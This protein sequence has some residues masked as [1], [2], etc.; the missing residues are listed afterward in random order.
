MHYKGKLTNTFTLKTTQ[1]HT[2]IHAH[3]KKLRKNPH[4]NIRKHKYT[5]THTLNNPQHSQNH[6]LQNT[7]LQKT[8]H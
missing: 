2:F 5:Q 6:T 7:N 4:S 3:I 1:L 8:T